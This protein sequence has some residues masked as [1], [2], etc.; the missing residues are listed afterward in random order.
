MRQYLLSAWHS[1]WAER[2]LTKY[3]LSDFDWICWRARRKPSRQHIGLYLKAALFRLGLKTLWLSWATVLL[4]CWLALSTW[5]N[6]NHHRW[7]SRAG[8]NSS[9][10]DCLYS[11]IWCRRAPPTVGGAIP[12]IEDYKCREPL[13]VNKHLHTHSFLSS[14]AGCARLAARSPASSS[15]SDA[16]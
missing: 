14:L 2:V 9:A 12:W 4:L 15:L 11:V 1:L 10:G 5:Y 3:S 8:W 6:M 13:N 7:L 16:L